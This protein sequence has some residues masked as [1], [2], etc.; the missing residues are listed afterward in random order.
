MMRNHQQASETAGV[1]SLNGL[2]MRQLRLL[3]GLDDE[4]KLQAAADTLNISQ[5]AASK[6]LAE[7]EAVV[8]VSLFERSARGLKPT[9]YGVILIRG[10]RSVLANLDQTAVE[11]AK[12]KAG[13]LGIVSIGAIEGPVAELVTGAVRDLGSSANQIEILIHVASS[14][15]LIERLLAF[16]LD[17]A[18]ARVP[19]SVDPGK[20][21]YCEIGEEEAMC[22]MVRAE[23]PLAGRNRLGLKDVSDQQWIF[24]PR[25]SFLGQ[26]IIQAF[27]QQGVAPPRHVINADSFLVS[28]AIAGKIDAIAPFPRP[29]LDLIDGR[30]FK[31]LELDV[32]LV[33][34]R[35]GL[36]KLRDRALSPAAAIVFDAMKRYASARRPDAV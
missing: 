24:Q 26:R 6:M 32:E 21:D 29:Y 25:G 16:D 13:G 33:L 27:Q 7:I 9:T 4:R 17:F 1:Q 2:K 28:L 23:H 30:H 20:L 22:L 12:H 19:S 31:I 10:A 11:L 5:S 15:G 34:E 36:I 35:Y 14:P 18:I 8:K 3:V